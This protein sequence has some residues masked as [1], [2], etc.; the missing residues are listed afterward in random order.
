MRHPRFLAAS[1]ALLAFICGTGCSG[2]G[3]TSNGMSGT[4]GVSGTGGAAGQPGGSGG[5]SAQPTPT[6]PPAPASCPEFHEGMASILSGGNQRTFQIYI[7]DAAAAAQN[8][9]IVFYWYGTSGTPTQAVQGLGADGIARIKAA[10]GLVIAPVHINTGIFPWIQ[11]DLSIEY[12]MMDDILGCA[13]S[14]VGVDARHVHTVGFSAGA[15]FTAQASFARSTYLASVAMYSGGGTGM[16]ADPTNLF[17]AMILYGGPN[18]MV[19]LSFQDQ[20]KQYYDALV[21]AAHF[22]F[23]CNHG[24]GHRI[25]A[26]AV[27]SVVQF[28][29][30]HPYGT[31]PSPY[32][33]GLPTG[34]PSYCML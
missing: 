23:E 25:P 1:T 33:A 3:G 21:G 14:K 2:D 17:A 34:F 15:L 7:D 31:S 5:G 29:F 26:D 16:F 18:D 4:G 12:Q 6:L 19:V 27:S 22:A 8:G 32:K 13:Q 10:G 24:G 28:L 30:D 9:P 11:G 20:S